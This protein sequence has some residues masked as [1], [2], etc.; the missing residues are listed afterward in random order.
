MLSQLHMMVS[1]QKTYKS[2]EFI[3]YSDEL[4]CRA[5]HYIQQTLQVFLHTKTTQHTYV[6]AVIAH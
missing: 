2:I 1:M 3:E 5:S 4:V 6:S